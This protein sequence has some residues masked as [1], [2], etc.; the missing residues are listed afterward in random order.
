MH[1]ELNIN[2]KKTALITADIVLAAYLLLACLSWH[3]PKAPTTKCN[4]VFINIADENEN[5]FLKSADVKKVLET[6]RIFPLS[7]QFN[8]FSVRDIEKRLRQMPFVKTAQCYATQ[9]GYIYVTVT[10]RTPVLRVKASS[11]DDYY[12]DDNGGIMPNSEYTSDMII[13]TGDFNR[14]YATQYLYYLARWFMNDD[15]WRNQIEQINILQDKTIEIIPRVGDH[16]IILGE[17]PNDTNAQKREKLITDFAAKQM[18]RLELFYRNG[19]CHAGWKKYDRISLE[20]NNQIVCRKRSNKPEET[21][22]NTEIKEKES[23][24]KE[25]EKKDE[26]KEQTQSPKKNAEEATT[27]KNKQKTS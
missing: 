21:K 8:E 22:E 3:K 18:H 11:G 19:L 20:F 2:W 24:I 25:E 16:I 10:Q 26:K 7:K 15:L 5:G 12:I 13:A 9:Q 4:R 17:L 27:D 1:L 14:M 6:N 23:T